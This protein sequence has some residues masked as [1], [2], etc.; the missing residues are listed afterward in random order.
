VHLEEMR[1]DFYRALMVGTDDFDRIGEL[2]DWI[3]APPAWHRDAA[4]AGM[5]QAQFFPGRSDDSRPAKAICAACL[6]PPNVSPTHSRTTPSAYGAARHRR[7]ATDAR[8]RGVM[9][10]QCAPRTA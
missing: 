6:S 3:V 10:C 4:C 8:E 7:T 9:K 1:E 2:L 5:P